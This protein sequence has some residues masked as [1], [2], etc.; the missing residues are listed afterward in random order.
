MSRDIFRNLSPLDTLNR[1]NFQRLASTIVI[2]TLPAGKILFKE[3]ENDSWMMYLLRGD[4]ELKDRNGVSVTISGGTNDSRHPVV[5]V[6]PR[7]ATALARTDIT[8]ALLNRKETDIILTWDQSSEHGISV[9]DNIEEESDW[10]ETILRAKI[11]YRIPPANIQA[12]F[13]N[14]EPVPFRQG[15]VVIREGE[16]GDYF[17]IVR[18]GK[19]KVVRYENGEMNELAELK[20]G[21]CF[22][23]DALISDS[24]RNATITMITDGILM[25]LGKEDFNSL[26]NEPMVNSI[27]MD[28]AQA[29]VSNGGAQWLD[30][31]LPSEHDVNNIK[32]S[33][34]IPLSSLRSEMDNL[35]R[36]KKYIV[37]CDSGRRSSAAAY[38]LCEND[39]DAYVL[40]G[41]LSSW[42]KELAS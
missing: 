40:E 24:K 5:D 3:G 9:D 12:V 18:E 22:G 41:G 10:T 36:G 14:M 17:Y 26:L 11:F 2:K 38:T 20:P 6:Q 19:C 42:N 13:M 27:N 39:I 8:I 23:E 37:Y 21:D 33:I 25:R 16:E 15:D 28:V 35:V 1:D 29:M 34:N 4:I 30:V 32:N 7:R 31:R